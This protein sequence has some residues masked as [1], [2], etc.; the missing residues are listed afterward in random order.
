MDELARLSIVFEGQIKDVVGKIDELGKVVKGL[1]DNTK[2]SNEKASVSWGGMASAVA[3]AQIAVQAFEF[4]L[5]KTVQLAKEA[6][7]E[8]D[9]EVVVIERLRAKVGEHVSGLILFAEAQSKVTRFT[10]DEYLAAEQTLS[11]HK[12]N[13]EQIKRLLPVIAD[14]AALKG[15]DL[16]SS[17]NAFSQAIQY[18]STRGLRDFG[19]ELEKTG[20][21]QSIFNTIIEAGAK[22]GVKD[23]AEKLAGIGSGPLIIVT[24]QIEEMKKKV[25]EALNPALLIFASYMKHEVMPGLENLAGWLSKN[26]NEVTSKIKSL[27]D[28]FRFATGTS[29]AEIWAENVIMNVRKVVSES[30]KN[31]GVLN[32]ALAT[33]K[34][35]LENIKNPNLAVKLF[36]PL[37]AKKRKEVVDRMSNEYRE[38]IGE[39]EKTIR[40]I[41]DKPKTGGATAAKTPEVNLLGTDLIKGPVK[42]K[43]SETLSANIAITNTKVAVEIEKLNILYEEGQLGPVKYYR[44]LIQVTNEGYDAEKRLLQLELSKVKTKEEKEAIR[45]KIDLLEV[46]RE[47]DKLK[48]LERYGKEEI[49]I[50]KE[51]T[52]GLVDADEKRLD[53]LKE[54]YQLYFDFIG[55]LGDVMG[56]M[57]TTSFANAGE[58][59]KATFKN[60]L[61]VILDF[62]E[63]YVLIVKLKL[64]FDDLIKLSFAGFI[65]GAIKAALVSA[66]FAVVKAGVTSMERGGALHGRRHTEGGIPIEAEDEE[67]IQ[68]RPA[69]RYYGMGVME[70]LNRRVIPRS[71]FAGF[72]TRA[73]A[74]TVGTFAEAGGAVRGG[75]G[76]KVNVAIF[77]DRKA[78]D[79]YLATAEGKNAIVHTIRQSK[80]NVN[81]VLR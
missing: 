60:M 54:K 7:T 57:F 18:G 2:E 21:Q 11:M 32:E 76:N 34:L 30:P 28:I 77:D 17:A 62:M 58:A 36:L 52:K 67:Y 80:Y 73:P 37:D 53:E 16:V 5:K 72:E 56:D 79:R 35:Q 39:I 13:S 81:K 61:L 31:I 33:M 71:V 9:N 20:S 15:R 42:E 74:M 10:H 38:I 45:K 12:L 59:L 70:A 41:D 46:K 55:R 50:A 69:T 51:T 25:G 65:T 68:S 6:I 27:M 49:K 4:A 8:Y 23:F 22:G 43:D 29:F 19:I 75:L 14:F 1:A 40:H 3:A 66:M 63:K 26:G 47:G 44:G 78:L 48:L 64:V 24:N